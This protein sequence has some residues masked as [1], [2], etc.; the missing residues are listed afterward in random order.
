MEKHSHL[1]GFGLLLIL[2][3]LLL[4]AS[5]F[6][7]PRSAA[8]QSG[9]KVSMSAPDTS[10]FPEI[11]FFFD[12]YNGEGEFIG[13]LKPDEVQV[14][15]DGAARLAQGLETT[16]P[17]VQFSVAFNTS[18]FYTTPVG[19]Q[20][21][22]EMMQTRLQAWAQ[23][24]PEET[25][26]DFS[27]TT[28]SASLAIHSQKTT[29]W[30]AAFQKFKPDLLTEQPALSSLTAALDLA[31]DPNPHQNMK[32]AIL[33]ITPLPTPPM[34]T[35][36]PNLAERAV[37][38]KVRIFVWLV[39]P[40][41]TTVEELVGPLRRMAERTGGKFFLFSG[42]EQLPDPDVYLEPLRQMY[43]LTYQSAIQQSGAH[44]LSLSVFRADFQGQSNEHIFTFSIEPP[45]PIF[46]A[47]PA[48]IQRSLQAQEGSRKKVL[49]PDQANIRILIEFPDGHQRAVQQTRFYVDG[50]LVDE[51][52]DAP[53]DEFDWPLD[54]YAESGT[55]LL[56]VEAVD[57]LGLARASIET[58][59]E[60]L[61]E[62]PRPSLF[63][64][65]IPWQRLAIAGSAL[66]AGLAVVLVLARRQRTHTRKSAAAAATAGRR[67]NTRPRKRAEDPLT[68]PVNIQQ[69]GPRLISGQTTPIYPRVIHRSGAPARLLLL[70]D[71]GR[72][73]PNCIILLNQ[74]EITL[75]S[76]ARLSMEV[77]N[78][79]SV[80]GLHA[81]ITQSAE[82]DFLIADAGSVAGTW[83]NYAP[84]SRQGVRLEHGDLINLGRVSF[85]FEHS[86]PPPPRQPVVTRLEDNE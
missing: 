19:G 22:F 83:V 30:A 50:V 2:V 56:K 31:T 1:S 28:N 79:S 70:S 43:R 49:L 34:L 73:L 29:D 59:V 74:P 40:A 82:G 80:E 18:G 5:L 24:Q 45:N 65:Q 26:D 39:A 61:V 41:N 84:V 11:S 12:A 20:T 33:Y 68:Q 13:N 77:L 60:V 76:D 62:Q 71:T 36:L 48:Q 54:Q 21:L 9:G 7:A 23:A 58:P 44:S 64:M 42:A 75:G 38:Q 53:F 27:L 14:L 15:E 55:H 63:A 57:I 78:N 25:S 66:V 81:R 85:R 17:G 52:L 8:G 4:A 10:A 35:A 51:N 46:L 3:S 16:R 67:V 86:N 72:P 37:L 32:R 69:D 6:N 47:P